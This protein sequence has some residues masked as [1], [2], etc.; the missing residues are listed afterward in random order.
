MKQALATIGVL[1]L[2]F[3]GFKF[4]QAYRR[5]SVP[6]KPKD[7]DCGCSKIPD[8]VLTIKL[9]PDG[10][11]NNIGIPPK[12]LKGF[13]LQNTVTPTIE[14]IGNDPARNFWGGRID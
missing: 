3:A 2:I 10:T 8:P 11:A 1:A 12:V 5:K 13:S 9:P 6:V 7:D 4:Y 14:A